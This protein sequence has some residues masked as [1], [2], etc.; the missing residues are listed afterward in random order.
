M[1]FRSRLFE[2]LISALSHVISSIPCDFTPDQG[3]KC[4]KEATK[5]SFR[6]L[7]KQSV[8]TLFLISRVEQTTESPA[9][10]REFGNS[11]VCANES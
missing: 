8:I 1:T 9:S 11:K 3:T 4:V 6:I 2:L 7:H 5:V 10:K